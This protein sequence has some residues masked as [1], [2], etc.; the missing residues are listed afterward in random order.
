MI[1]WSKPGFTIRGMTFT[2]FAR[3]AASTR[4]STRPQI[5]PMLSIENDCGATTVI[6]S[7]LARKL[8]TLG[9]ASVE[10]QR[11]SLWAE[12]GRGASDAAAARR[13]IGNS[14]RIVSASDEGE[15]TVP[16]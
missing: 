15:S 3:A 4:E 2:P 1:D 13:A 7:A 14:R 11:A 16:S 12:A 5:V 10:Y 6:L 9:S 8:C